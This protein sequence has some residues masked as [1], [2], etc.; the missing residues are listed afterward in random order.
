MADKKNKYKIDFKYNLSIFWS[1]LKKYNLIWITLLFLI[2][3]IEGKYIL[4]KFLFKVIIDKGTEFAA[5]NLAKEIFINILIIIGMIFL[6]LI[7]L[8]AI[9]K[10]FENHLLFKLESRLIRDLKYKFFNHIIS[11]DQKFHVTHKTGSLISRLMRGS[12]AIERMTDV[13]IYSFAPFILQTIIAIASIVYFNWISALTIFITAMVFILFSFFMQK[14]QESSNIDLNKT[15]DLEKGIT[16]DFFTNIDSIRYF[17]KESSIKAKY[18]K[19]VDNSTA[20]LVKNWNYF[21]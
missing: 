20:K 1:F 14:L 11:L 9:I 21:R 13:F 7:I 2:L 16:A 17:G 3:L 6:G 19:L 15:Q 4:D 8:N 5:G 12:S 18:K 10:W